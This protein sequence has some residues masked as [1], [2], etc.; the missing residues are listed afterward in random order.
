MKLS[1]AALVALF[2]PMAAGS[3]FASDRFDFRYDDLKT[4]HGLSS[5]DNMNLPEGSAGGL[6]RGHGGTSH[7]KSSEY[8]LPE[9]SEAERLSISRDMPFAVA[10][11][12]GFSHLDR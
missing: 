2:V 1:V 7:M 9:G 4:R 3:A 11:P 8:R 5:G 6:V 10:R 12:G